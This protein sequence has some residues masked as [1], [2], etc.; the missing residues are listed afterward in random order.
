M[1][2][3]VFLLLGCLVLVHYKMMA[4]AAKNKQPNIIVI[5]SDDHDQSAI[6]AYGS[7]LFSTPNLDRIANEGAL[8]LQSFVGNSICAPS[9]A[10]LLTGKHSHKNG[11]IDNQSEFDGSQPTLPKY[12]K[13]AGYK[14]ALIGKWHLKSA[15]TGFDNWRVLNDQGEYYNP[16]FWDQSGR[17][18]DSGYVTELITDQALRW[19]QTNQE[20]GKPFMLMVQHK[21][22]HR[23]W[24][25][26]VKFMHA[27][28]D[29]SFPVPSSLFTTGDGAAAK[30]QL[31]GIENDMLP[32]GDLK[33]HRNFTRM[34]NLPVSNAKDDS[35][36]F[37]RELKR[38]NPAQRQAWLR[39]Q[40]QRTLDFIKQQPT[41]NELVI[42]KYQH[43]MRDYLNCVRSVDEQVGRLLNYLDSTGL[44]KNTI[45]IYTSDQGFWLGQ[46]GWFD[47]RFMYDQS[48]RT[49]L[50]VK[51]PGKV[52]PGTKV[53]SLV[54]NIDLA[55][56]LLDLVGQP[57][58]KDMQGVSLK[59]PLLSGKPLA[60]NTLYYR[61]YEYPQ[62]HR[63][64][65][66]YGVRTAT[67]KLI[68]FPMV[69]EFE[70]YDLKADP[71]ELKN[72]ATD[73]ANAILLAEMQ[74]LLKK[75]QLVY[76]D[77]E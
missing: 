22:P 57:V 52:K 75:T 44:S 28:D 50:L 59:Q 20:S 48:M 77:K 19:L 16:V 8:F 66:H 23:G 15:P 70:L 42:W 1:S 27:L 68:Y 62:P 9:R 43:Y 30:H 36:Y 46:R 55:P 17:H 69:K 31:M 53:N 6:S 4:Q 47:K 40:D 71:A 10:A 73:P 24:V 37:H 67:H 26:P 64:M 11:H 63:V 74:A 5:H 12:L 32:S 25:P 29:Q 65:P 49:P 76:G 41:G 2:F 7:G 51:W 35:N 21:A 14:T 34:A 54:Q 18:V 45:V 61:Y 39:L 56:T 13:Q 3:R 58:P 72:L 60:R 33:L 38:M